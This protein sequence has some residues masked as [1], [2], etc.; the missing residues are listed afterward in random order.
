MV[1]GESI[2]VLLV[3]D[4]ADLRG[5][6]ELLLRDVNEV[7]VV[8]SLESADRLLES[9]ESLDPHV[10]ILDLSMPGKNPFTALSAAREKFPAVRFLVSSSF[11]DEGQIDRAFE[12]GAAGYLVK[13]GDINRLLEAIHC[14]ARGER[15]IIRDGHSRERPYP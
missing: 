3:D 9:I 12:A 2:R 4:S 1:D 5:L 6:L 7:T 11:D 14:V 13:D 8:G 15:P 10:V